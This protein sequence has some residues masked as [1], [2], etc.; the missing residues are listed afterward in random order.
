MFFE[1][2]LLCY[3]VHFIVLFM[4]IRTL[5]WILL[6]AICLESLRSLILLKTFFLLFYHRNIAYF[7]MTL[8]K[9]K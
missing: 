3:D 6:S 5:S 8:N 1:Y 2:V 9:A 4:N 7:G